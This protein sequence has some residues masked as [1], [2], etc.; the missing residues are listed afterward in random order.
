MVLR[1]YPTL[2]TSAREDLVVETFQNALGE[3]QLQRHVFV[4]KATTLAEAV[5]LATEMG[6]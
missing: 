5:N 6:V 3:E 4:K 2:P 1:S